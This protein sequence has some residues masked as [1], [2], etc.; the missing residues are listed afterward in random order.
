MENQ[1]ALGLAAEANGTMYSDF[2]NGANANGNDSNNDEDMD[3]EEEELKKESSKSLKRKKKQKLKADKEAE[4]LE[5][6]LAVMNK[7]RKRLYNRMQ[8]GLKGKQDVVD[9]L[10][11]KRKKHLEAQQ[12]RDEDG[13]APVRKRSKRTKSKN[14]LEKE[15]KRA[16][17]ARLEKPKKK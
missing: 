3:S 6:Q 17:R 15:V 1:Y 5:R 12:V 9:N 2:A 11:E 14:Q 4:H 13:D 10:L 7:K 16:T 8:H